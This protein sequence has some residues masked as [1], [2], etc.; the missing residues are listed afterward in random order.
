[1][2]GGSVLA[3][4]KS[5]T[6]TIKAYEKIESMIMLRELDSDEMY[7]EGQLAAMVKLGRTPVREALQ[8]LAHERVVQIIPYRGIQV[9]PASV[10]TQLKLL[11]LRREVEKLCVR[12]SV[13]RATTA[14]KLVMK[15]QAIQIVEC[16]EQGDDKSFVKLLKEIHDTIITSTGNEFIRTT[17]V[18]LQILSRR[19]WFYH[20]EKNQS[21][22]HP[23][24]LHAD[25]LNAIVHGSEAT[26]EQASE[27][28][29]DYLTDFTYATLRR[30]GIINLPSG[31]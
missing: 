17:M 12:L 9:I 24:H 26:A 5:E 3:R 14:Q 31:G 8:R 19:F 10:E 7:S 20:Q 13:A 1:M 16:A 15:E 18:P 4:A 25:I 30:Q 27:A 22:V 21:K 28:L 29:M 23:A 2:K 11:E 6:Q